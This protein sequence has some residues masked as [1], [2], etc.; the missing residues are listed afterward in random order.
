MSPI[1]ELASCYY[2]DG[3]RTQWFGD[4]AFLP[5]ALTHTHVNPNR[6]HHHSSSSSQEEPVSLHL[7]LPPAADDVPDTYPAWFTVLAIPSGAF[8]LYSLKPRKWLEYLACAISG[9]AG[10]VL[11]L[12]GA[13]AHTPA[14][15]RDAPVRAGDAY[16]YHYDSGGAPPCF[17][18]PDVATVAPSTSTSTSTSTRRVRRRLRALYPAC[19]FTDLPGALCDTAYLVP[20]TKGDA[21][22]RRLTAARSRGE[23]VVAGVDD[24]RNDVRNALRVRP[25]K[26]QP[27]PAHTH[28]FFLF[29]SSTQT[30]NA[31]LTSADVAPPLSPSASLAT[32][33]VFAQ[34]TP[35]LTAYVGSRSATLPDAATRPP[36]VLLAAVYAGSALEERACTEAE[37]GAEGARGDGDA[38]PRARAREGSDENGATNSSSSSFDAFDMLLALRRMIHKPDDPL[39]RAEAEAGQRRA[40]VARVQNWLTDNQP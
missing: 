21:Y 25:G 36:D 14:C 10:G 8:P 17:V 26:Q 2:I 3:F 38:Q 4:H 35:P 18:D 40:S 32:L 15:D 13:D 28:R 37:T 20:R 5:A 34:T 27:H 9:S 29:F 16:Y 30:P 33:H 7:R 23:C 6:H 39:R 1:A 22:I 31:S 11:S 12:S 19:P 24:V